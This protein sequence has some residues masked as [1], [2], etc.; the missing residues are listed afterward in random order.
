MPPRHTWHG[1]RNACEEMD[2]AVIPPSNQISSI[3]TSFGKTTVDMLA[4]TPQGRFNGVFDCDVSACISAEPRFLRA[5]RGE[6]AKPPVIMKD[7]DDVVAVLKLVNE[8]ES[9]SDEEPTILAV[10]MLPD[11]GLFAGGIYGIPRDLGFEISR[12]STAHQLSSVAVK[13]LVE[14]SGGPLPLRP[15][16]FVLD[17][18][19]RKAIGQQRTKINAKAEPPLGVD[20][21]L[22]LAREQF[23]AG[24]KEAAKNGSKL[25]GAIAGWEALDVCRLSPYNPSSAIGIKK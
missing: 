13:D 16:A 12:F 6:T 3:V 10:N 22:S 9:L 19:I 4:A 11:Q 5:L 21:V 20:N 7:G 14:L 2:S 25:L 18:D 23:R 17:N 15:S 1:I 8:T 24:G